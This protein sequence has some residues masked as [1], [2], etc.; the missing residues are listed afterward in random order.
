MTENK[1]KRPRDVNQ[2]AKMMVDVASGECFDQLA[3]QPNSTSNANAVARGKARAK[4][5]TASQRSEI[6]KIAATA[7]WK[8]SD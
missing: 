8:K 1:P 7:R 5:L 6:A 4:V 2:L 3:A